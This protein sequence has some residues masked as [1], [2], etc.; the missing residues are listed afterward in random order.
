MDLNLRQARAFLAV[1]E[2]GSFT[3]AAALL[4]VSQPALTV[5]IRL[6]E[7]ALGHRLLDRTS[8]GVALTRIGRELQPLLARTL[9]DADAV[10]QD[11]HAL[12]RSGGGTVRIAVLPSFAA[13]LL[14]ELI[15]RHRQDAPELRFVVRDAVASVVND[16]VAREEV[17]IGLTGGD[18][19][20]P[21]LEPVVR[22][23]DRL[24]VVFPRGHPVQD[25]ARVTGRD[26]AK[27]PLI[28]TARGTS[29][30]AVVDA[31]FESLGQPPQLSG[32]PT[33]MMTAVAM[34]RAGLGLTILP[35]WAREASCE[36]ELAS[37]PI[38]DRRFVRPVTL[39][40]RR[41]RTLPPA[42]QAF[43]GVVAA[44]MEAAR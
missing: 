6:L 16:L 2:H 5:Q 43:L 37:R 28:L 25:K 34:V 14:P 38:D 30:R 12:A 32:E 44:A 41:G 31:A 13:S 20:L 23:R 36:P 15:R 7:Q 27:L 21:E 35:E 9:H 1:A 39:V 33:Y 22:A 40:R 26:L 4:H 24:H 42:A 3:R 11:A 10:L 29:V 17:D 8:R 19:D 18:V